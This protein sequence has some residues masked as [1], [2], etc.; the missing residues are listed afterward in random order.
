[1]AKKKVEVFLDEDIIAWLDEKVII[2]TKEGLKTSRSFLM[3]RIIKER[4]DNEKSNT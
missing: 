2:A 1:M 4:I 3:Y